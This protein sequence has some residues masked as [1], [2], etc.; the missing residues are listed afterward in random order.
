[1]TGAGRDADP[2]RRSD[3]ETRRVTAASGGERP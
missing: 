1:M 3:D 2:F